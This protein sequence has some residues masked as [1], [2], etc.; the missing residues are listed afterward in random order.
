MRV[1][2]LYLVAI[3]GAEVVTNFGDPLW[4]IICHA[5]LLAALLAHSSWAVELPIH[6]LLLSLCLIPLIR[7][8]SLSMPTPIG[9]PNT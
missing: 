2:I 8:T 5:V 6:K 1:A 7:I 4:G 3:T 9:S